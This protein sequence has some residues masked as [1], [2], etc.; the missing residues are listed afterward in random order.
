MRMRCDWL[1]PT[2]GPPA[3]EGGVYQCLLIAG[4]EGEHFCR[5]SSSPS[6]RSRKV[7]VLWEPEDCSG[8]CGDACSERCECFLWR[9]LGYGEVAAIFA[10]LRQDRGLRFKEKKVPG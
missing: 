8:D 1:L 7:Y 3:S 6:L 9:E 5:I 10:K 2:H 4:H